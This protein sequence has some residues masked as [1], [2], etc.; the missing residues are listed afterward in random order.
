MVI[1]VFDLWVSGAAGSI[2]LT[3]SNIIKLCRQISIQHNFNL[4]HLLYERS[5]TQ[6]LI[7]G[8]TAYI[9]SVIIYALQILTSIYKYP[10][11]V[12]L[13]VCLYP[14]NVKT[15]ERPKF[16]MNSGKKNGCTVKGKILKINNLWGCGSAG[17]I[18]LTGFNNL[19]RQIRTQS[20]F[21]LFLM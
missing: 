10:L 5:T 1:N 17:S 7:Q 18:S 8:K 21:C 12:C 3:G 2:K 13:C 14:V 9:D 11:L 16:F 19:C 15:A 20:N 4:L 6:N